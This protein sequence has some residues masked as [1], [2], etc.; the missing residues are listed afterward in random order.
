MLRIPPF[1]K[2]GDLTVYQDDGIWNRFTLIPAMPIEGGF[3]GRPEERTA[4]V[5]NAIGV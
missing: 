1:R 2:I 4:E 3:S 5:A